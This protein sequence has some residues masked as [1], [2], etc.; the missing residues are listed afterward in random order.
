[1]PQPDS[2]FLEHMLQ[3]LDRI[4]ELVNRT[5]RKAFD[6]DWVVQDALIRELEIIGEAAGRVS[7]DLSEAYPE[8]PWR[9]ITGL[10]HKLIHDYFSVDLGIVWT[11]ATEDVA[12]VRPLI[13]A[14]LQALKG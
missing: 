7:S 8:I 1:M 4:E 6:Q 14:A 11:T 10:R 12:E 13:E 5:D 3:A 2:L 9:E